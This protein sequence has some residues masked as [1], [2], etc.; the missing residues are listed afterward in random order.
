MER[1]NTASCTSHNAPSWILLQPIRCVFSCLSQKWSEE[2][3]SPFHPVYKSLYD[4][5][6]AALSFLP[7]P[8]S[9][10]YLS[11]SLHP[12]LHAPSSCVTMT[13]ANT[14]KS[15]LVVDVKTSINAHLMFLF[16]SGGRG[17]EM[18][19]WLVLGSVMMTNKVGEDAGCQNSMMLKNLEDLPILAFVDGH[20]L[21]C[22]PLL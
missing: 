8:Y 10:P 15:T 11:L 1:E 13:S 9:S 14:S 12:S 20:L 17:E 19:L 3:R 7:L 6:G 16:I 4:V 2:W 22:V 21:S 18:N 5:R